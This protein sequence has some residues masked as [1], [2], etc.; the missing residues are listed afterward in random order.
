MQR[1]CRR[2]HRRGLDRNFGR[3]GT[4]KDEVAVKRTNA[5]QAMSTVPGA[6]F[7]HSTLIVDT[8]R[9]THR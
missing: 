6:L 5:S 2:V 3:I 8:K 1:R 4:V 7:S 9:F